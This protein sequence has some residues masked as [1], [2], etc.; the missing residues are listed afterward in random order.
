MKCR[1]APSVLRTVFYVVA[2]SSVAAVAQQTQGRR[3][4]A[5]G[6]INRVEDLPVSRLRAHIEALP[7]TART[8]AISWLHDFHFTDLDLNSLEVDQDGS[9]Y[10]AD[11]F[12][13]AT[14]E[15]GSEP[16]DPSVGQ[17][18]VPVS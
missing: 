15:P 8:R 18:A 11:S 6:A 10:Y 1:L 12:S 7:A 16:S 4:F 9:V 13:V 2:C 3:E 17:A 14:N 5:P